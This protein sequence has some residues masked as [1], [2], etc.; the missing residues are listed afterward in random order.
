MYKKVRLKYRG[1]VEREEEGE[2]HPKYKCDSIEKAI[3]F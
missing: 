1:I 3:S 2:N